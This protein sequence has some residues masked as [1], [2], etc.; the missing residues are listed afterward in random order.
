MAKKLRSRVPRKIAK[1]VTA[2][3]K[4]MHKYQ[5]GF[6]SKTCIFVTYFTDESATTG[7]IGFCNTSSNPFDVGMFSSH[8]ANSQENTEH[9]YEKE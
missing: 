9:K 2:S 3:A 1:V 8:K 7:F 6:L 5:T 4:K